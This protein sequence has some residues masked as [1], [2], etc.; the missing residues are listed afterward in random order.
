VVAD[1][2]QGLRIH[3]DVG[4]VERAILELVVA[5]AKQVPV[6][7]VQLQQALLA[8]LEVIDP[9]AQEQRGVAAAGAADVGL[10]VDEP[11]TRV[12]RRG[13]AERQDDADQQ[14]CRESAHC[15]V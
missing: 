1:L 10:H 8:Q 13:Q 9:V 4:H 14:A 7:P 3:R 2:L 5:E 11:E 6:F 12:R 15:V